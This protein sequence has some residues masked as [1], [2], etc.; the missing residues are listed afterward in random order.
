MQDMCIT[1][2]TLSVPLN[3]AVAESFENGLDF[4]FSKP[5]CSEDEW[6]L[7]GKNR[8]IWGIEHV[9]AV[10]DTEMWI[11]GLLKRVQCL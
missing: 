8:D 5:F 11:I 10:C 3:K 4:A 1:Y 9:R 6:S 2:A 7:P